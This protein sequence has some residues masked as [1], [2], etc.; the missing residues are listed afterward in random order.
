M[1]TYDELMKV[2]QEIQVSSEI[3]FEHLSSSTESRKLSDLANRL[4]D[5]AKAVQ[6]TE[7]P[8]AW[9]FGG[10]VFDAMWDAKAIEACNA[11]S[12]K[13]IP[14]YAA[15]HANSALAGTIKHCEDEINSLKCAKA[16]M[17]YGSQREYIDMMIDKWEFVLRV[18]YGRSNQRG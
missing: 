12:V 8:V 6:V 18:I 16:G 17:P 13:G 3:V 5:I 15:P 9:K 14:L 10:A 2:A 4:V 11:S 7:E 1:S